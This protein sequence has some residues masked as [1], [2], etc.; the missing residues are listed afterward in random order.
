V[1]VGAAAIACAGGGPLPGGGQARGSKSDGAQPFPSP[2]ELEKLGESKL[3]E[4]VFGLDVRRVA[5]WR[6]AGPFPERVETL[7]YSDGSPASAL[8]DEAARRRVGLA[9]PTESMYCVARELGRFYL[10]TG[11]RPSASLR[12]FITT[13][14]HAPVAWVGF[15]YTGGPVPAERGEAEILAA[16]RTSIEKSIEES[17]TGGPR[18]IGIWFGREPAPEDGGP[19][20]AERAVV[21]VAFGSREV[22]V[23][24]IATIPDESGRLVIRG[25]ALGSAGDVSAIANRGEY[26]VEECEPLPGVRLPRFAF[27]CALDPADPATLISLAVTPRESFLSNLALQVLAWPQ[28]KRAD[29]WREVAYA[30]SRIA[31]DLSS[32]GEDLTELLNEVRARAGLRPVVLDP[33]QSEVAAELA[34]PFFASVLERAPHAW[35]E[36]AVLGILAGWDVDGTVQEG[37]FTSSWAVQDPDLGRLLS[38]ALEEPRGREALLAADVERIAVGGLREGEG[39]K[40]SIAAV[41][42]TYELFSEADH[43]RSVR[44]VID[45]LTRQRAR[46]R[47]GPPRILDELAGPCDDASIRVTNGAEPSDAMDLL[48]RESVE[49]LGRAT[50][51]WVAEVGELDDLEFPDEYVKQRDLELAVAV[52]HR[53]RKGDAWGRYVVML[54]IVAPESRSA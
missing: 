21:M 24:P 48:L 11:G 4:A 54:V 30:G 25:E 28:G 40:S 49:G 52:S 34:G 44:A 22:H 35:A 39:E 45:A 16:W 50:T 37:H 23:E 51:G 26:G 47:L 27:A 10:A 46:H 18:A 38:D 7:A 8:L 3:P 53:K 12:R 13:R 9:V 41:F 15:S 1:A 5:E 2:E 19:E 29:T 36:V 14:C 42:G 32:V 6:L 17:L 20:Q 33:G 31:G 43:D